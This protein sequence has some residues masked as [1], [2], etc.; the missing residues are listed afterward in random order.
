MI[1][2]TNWTYA[3]QI[4]LSSIFKVLLPHC[5]YTKK[6]IFIH[7]F[8]K[9]YIYM[10]TNIQVCLFFKWSVRWNNLWKKKPS[11]KK[12]KGWKAES[13]R[14]SAGE[15]DSIFLV[16]F[17]DSLIV[18]VCAHACAHAGT[19]WEESRSRLCIFRPLC[20]MINIL[21]NQCFKDVRSS[22]WILLRPVH[23]ALSLWEDTHPQPWSRQSPGHLKVREALLQTGPPPGFPYFP[24]GNN[25]LS[26]HDFLARQFLPVMLG[27]LTHIKKLIQAVLWADVSLVI[28]ATEYRQLGGWAG[29]C[30]AQGS[31]ISSPE[32]LQHWKKKMTWFLTAPLVNF[33]DSHCHPFSVG[34][35]SQWD[36]KPGVV[37]RNSLYFSLSVN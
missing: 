9:I 32:F 10:S 35:F 6:I 15:L 12:Q 27:R 22:I 16:L 1:M 14:V 23:P 26:D 34:V 19:R 29:V 11:P 33:E 28:S 37:G 8:E 18:C 5:L 7:L 17:W 24:M 3:L 2:T 20:M 13:F 4:T 30:G 36:Y 31:P 21:K 25:A